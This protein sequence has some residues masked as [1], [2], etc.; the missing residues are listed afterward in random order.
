MRHTGSSADHTEMV[1]HKDG[2][3]AH[4][5]LCRYLHKEGTASC[6]AS[7]KDCS[8]HILLDQGRL[9]GLDTVAG[10]CSV[11]PDSLGPCFLNTT[12]YMD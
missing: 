11:V 8:D 1:S 5:D 3:V 2:A 6:L 7:H 4:M 10:E 12:R 9:V